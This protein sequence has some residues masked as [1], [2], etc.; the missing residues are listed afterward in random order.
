MI[1]Q[2]TPQGKI[3]TEDDLQA[4]F[5]EALATSNRHKG[6]SNFYGL[7]AIA[8]NYVVFA[9]CVY[10]SEYASSHFET[11]AARGTYILM[12]LVIGSRMRAFEN[13][14]HEAS[15]NNLFTNPRAHEWLEFT[16]AFPVFRLLKSYR[17]LHLEHHKYLGDPV[18]DADVVR[19]IDHGFIADQ[20]ISARRKTW[21][22]FGL[23]FTG[24]LH[25]EYMNTTFTEFWSDPARY[26]L[27][28]VFWVVVLSAVHF[29]NVWEGFGKYYAVPLFGILPVT[30]WWAELGEHIGMDMTQ[31]FGNSRTNDG[32]LQ[33]WWI[34]P[35]NDGLH[36]AHHLNS[37]IPFHRLRQAHRE[38]VTESKAFREKNIVANGMWETFAQMYRPTKIWARVKG[39]WNNGHQSWAKKSL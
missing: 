3:E 25:Y 33:R 30:R 27:K 10:L 2:P 8:N 15:H 19:F 29:C 1:H 17:T 35:P 32:F 14:V 37:Q 18:R 5:R 6:K 21:L 26:P 9:L 28:L 31:N 24:W 11:A 38:L 20:P 23:P 22:M 4:A 7:L 16:Y 36:A 12:V 13:L 34:H 39:V